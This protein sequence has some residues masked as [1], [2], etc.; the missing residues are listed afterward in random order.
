MKQHGAIILCG[1]NS[2]RMGRDK[3]WLPFGH[4]LMLQRVVRLVSEVVE[5]DKIVVVAARGQE[6]PPLPNQIKLTYDA[7]PDRGPLEGLAAGL[8]ATQPGV[9]ATYVTGCDVP[10]L[11][12]AFI[13]KML[14]LLG[15]HDIVVPVEGKHK[16]P[17]AAVYRTQVLRPLEELLDNDQL[18][19]ASLFSKV[20]TWEVE[21]NTLESVDPHFTS[22]VNCNR[23]EDYHEALAGL[24]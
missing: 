18:R 5:P 16:H 10:L 6:L 15:D 14:T 19:P 2:S 11:V 9:D 21:V 13:Q 22:L 3:A 7:R 20:K 12:P 23:P 17:L 4:E 1:G 8:R 24:C